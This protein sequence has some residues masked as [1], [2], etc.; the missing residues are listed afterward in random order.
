MD[1]IADVIV[2]GSGNAALCAAIAAAE[3]GAKVLVLERAPESARGGNSAFAGG[4][5]RVAYDG[6]A[7]I[8]RLVPDLSADEEEKSDFGTYPAQQYF[9]ELI[10]MSDFRADGDLIA[11]LVD[12][13]LDTLLWMRSH[14]VRW[15]PIHGRQSFLVNGKHRFWGGLTVE[16]SGGGAGLINSLFAQTVRLGIEVRFEHKA[17]DLLY[18][19]GRITGVVALSKGEQI[20]LRAGAV[21]LAAGGFH[22]NTEWRA[23]YLGQNWD[24][25]KVR[26]SRYNTGLMIEAALRHGARAAGHW[27]A[28]HSVFYDANAPAF[29]DPALL[30]QQ[31]NYIN[32]GI[33]VNVD[34]KRFVDEG[35][36]F[37]NYI[38]SRMG[39]KLLAQPGGRGWQIFDAAAHAMLPDE[40][41]VHH[42][43]RF[44]APS[45]EALANKLES[46]NKDGFLR[47]MHEFNAAIDR[48]VPFNPAVLDGRRTNGLSVDKTNWAN[49]FEQGPFFAY[50]IS[51]G[52]TCTYGGVAI[53]P[54]AQ[55]INEEGFVMPGLYAAG[56]MV[57]GLYFTK[58]PGGAGLTAGAVFGRRAGCHAAAAVKTE[59]A[60]GTSR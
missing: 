33:V 46:L 10:G 4:A 32:L 8:K 29:G 27:S 21:I 59:R 48:R 2:I 49:P 15:L 6:V 20:R 16:V 47:T 52:I 42:A 35:E 34:G 18:E 1:H 38:Y 9:D 40:Y 28:C 58:Y 41:R 53:T 7:D 3:S 54:D 44:E 12:D 39:G 11:A 17:T 31:K 14:G 56:E 43:T 13:S 5:F 36:N 25:A 30:N 22:A 37:R 45:L 26:G 57:G 51:C 50:E 24:L 23:R 19:Q 60:T 55:V